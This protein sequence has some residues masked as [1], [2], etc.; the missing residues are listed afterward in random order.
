[1]NLQQ[2]QTAIISFK[3][4]LASAK[5]SEELY[6]WESLFHFQNNWDFE[7]PDFGEMY[8]KSLQNSKTKRLWKSESYT[9]KQMMG[10]LIG[11]NPEFVQH[12]FKDLFREEGNVADRIDRFIYYCDDLLSEYKKANPL[13]IENNHYQDYQ[14][15]ALYLTFRYPEQYTFYDFPSFQKGMQQLGSKNI[16]AT[17]DIERFFKTS[18]IIW[19]FM[20]KDEEVWSLHQQ[21]LI[22][23]NLYQGKS[24]LLVHEFFKMLHSE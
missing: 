10:I 8:N 24:L 19:N 6:K 20:E 11:M 22:G 16:P 12:I 21:R 4:Y 9:P 13:S 18:K 7:H 1:M 23:K 5:S 2:L 15:I 14:M 17:N 3:T